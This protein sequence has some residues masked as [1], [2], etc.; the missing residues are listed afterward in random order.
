MIAP[1]S[2]D[3]KSTGPSTMERH[4]VPPDRPPI[5]PGEDGEAAEEE[6]DS[7]DEEAG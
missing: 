7:Q 5:D 2:K 4:P 6:D 3:R 1:I